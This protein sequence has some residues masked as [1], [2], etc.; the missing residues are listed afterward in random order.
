MFLVN[1]L[2][3]GAEPLNPP[4][5]RVSLCA[6]VR[7]R[8][9]SCFQL[10]NVQFFVFV[11]PNARKNTDTYFLSLYTYHVCICYLI[12]LIIDYYDVVRGES[13]CCEQCFETATTFYLLKRKN[14]R[15]CPDEI[16]R[17]F[18]QLTIIPPSITVA[19]IK[20]TKTKL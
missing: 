2:F 18:L 17:L 10:V 15:L 14:E 20:K 13:N 5:I 11:F 6:K 7:L 3:N 19:S 12:N 9:L 1:I 4:I 8:R 16:R